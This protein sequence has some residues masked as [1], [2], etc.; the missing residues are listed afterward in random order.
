MV[1][2]VQA[3]YDG[4]CVACEGG[5]YEDDWIVRE[6]YGWV[7]DNCPEVRSR[8]VCNECWMEI[9]PSGDCMC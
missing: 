6:S 3:A 4:T 2:K 9:A 1:L 7:H 5:I 8:P